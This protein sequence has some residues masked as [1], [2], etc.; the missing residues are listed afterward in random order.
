MDATAI[1][2]MK[3]YARVE[4]TFD[5]L[6]NAGIGDGDPLTVDDWHRAATTGNRCGTRYEH[7]GK[8]G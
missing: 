7:A 4:R 1:K 3:L 2:T 8:I 5:E 6:R